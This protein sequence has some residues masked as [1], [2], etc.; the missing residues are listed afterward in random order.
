MIALPDFGVQSAEL[1]FIDRGGIL[2]PTL[3]GPDQRLDRLG[4]R[5]GM[6]TQTKPMK[7]EEARVWI[8]RLVRGIREKASLKLSQP[9][10]VISATRDFVVNGNHAANVEVLAI[11]VGFSDQLTKTFSEGQFITII[12]GG[13]RFVYQITIGGTVAV[14][15]GAHQ[16]SLGI[17]PPLRKAAA[18]GD[19]VEVL[20][21]RIEG[22]IQGDEARWN[23][24][25]AKIY[26]LSFS[27]DEAM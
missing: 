22:Y 11:S 20:A 18:S 2:R 7:G 23:I 5:W 17:Q 16:V 9:G 21:P 25:S 13:Q 8:A 24:D 4:G 27:I 1:R 15:G 12:T 26:G 6:N 19:V 14:T 10:V 3:G